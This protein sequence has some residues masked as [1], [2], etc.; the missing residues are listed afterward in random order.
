MLVSELNG[1]TERGKLPVIGEVTEPNTIAR[2]LEHVEARQ[3]HEHDPRAPPVLLA[4]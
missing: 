2:I 3:R 1:L 4:T